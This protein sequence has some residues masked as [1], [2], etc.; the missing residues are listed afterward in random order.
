MDSVAK[1]L[2]LDRYGAKLAFDARPERRLFPGLAH[3]RRL[4][5][6]A[7]LDAPP[8]QAPRS[9]CRRAPALHEEDP[10][11]TVDDDGAYGEDDARIGLR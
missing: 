4:R 7:G 6:L 11:R 8:W 10:P 3:D 2:A 1:S 5:R 9:D